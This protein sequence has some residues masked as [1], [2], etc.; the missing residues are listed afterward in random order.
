MASVWPNTSPR[1]LSVEVMRTDRM[2]IQRLRRWVCMFAGA[3]IYTCISRSLSLSLS[4][5]LCAEL[6]N[7]NRWLKPTDKPDNG[8]ASSMISGSPRLFTSS[9]YG[10]SILRIGNHLHQIACC[11]DLNP[12][13]LFESKGVQS[14]LAEQYPWLAPRYWWLHY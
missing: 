4:L 14:V 1:W 7:E 10:L 12:L 2:P 3:V 11:L 6:C 5:S 13:R 8:F 9:G